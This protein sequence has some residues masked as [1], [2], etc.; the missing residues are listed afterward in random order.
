ME[1]ITSEAEKL[2]QQ[3]PDAQEHIASKHE[4]MVHAWNTLLEKAQARKDKLQAAENLQMYF[5]DYRELL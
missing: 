3:F 1:S 2:L 5:N 4:E